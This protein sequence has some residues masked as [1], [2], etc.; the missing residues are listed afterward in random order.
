[1]PDYTSFRMNAP[2]S[3][4]SCASTASVREK[5][6]EETLEEMIVFESNLD[7]FEDAEK[8]I[9]GSI[10]LETIEEEKSINPVNAP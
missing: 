6:E 5:L 1:M 2:T 9:F 4:R 8:E 3:S 10:E 7:D